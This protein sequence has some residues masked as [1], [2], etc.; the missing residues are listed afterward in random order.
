MAGYSQD[1]VSEWFGRY[2]DPRYRMPVPSDGRVTL[3]RASLTGGAILPGDY[4]TESRTY[5]QDHIMANLGGEGEI[6]SV[7][8]DFDDIFPADGPHEFWYAP[9]AL[10]GFSSMED[11]FECLSSSPGQTPKP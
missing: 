2:A 6:V 7:E 10:D 11:L 9:A 5:A 4:V 3:Y 1:A 8:A